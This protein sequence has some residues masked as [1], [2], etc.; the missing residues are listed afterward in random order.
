MSPPDHAPGVNR[1][2]DDLLKCALRERGAPMTALDLAA[3]VDCDDVYVRRRLKKL[4][5][6]GDVTSGVA[7]RQGASGRPSATFELAELGA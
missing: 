7:I 6:A 1:G 4:I 2:I 5:A 3:A